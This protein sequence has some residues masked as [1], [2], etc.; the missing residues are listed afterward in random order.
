[1][2]IYFNYKQFIKNY[3]TDI[4]I[5]YHNYEM[6]HLLRSLFLFIQGISTQNTLQFHYINVHE[7][8]SSFVKIT[9]NLPAI[10]NDIKQKKKQFICSK[11]I[12]VFF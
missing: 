9:I 2:I 7:V 11:Y 1:M 3:D 12:V 4:I 5:G 10:I 8:S 6:N